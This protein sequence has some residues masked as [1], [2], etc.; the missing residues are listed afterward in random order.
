LLA[1]GDQHGQRRLV[2]RPDTELFDG[3][4][5]QRLGDRRL[6]GAERRERGP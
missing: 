4:A 6:V 3:L 5:G 1:H 2:F